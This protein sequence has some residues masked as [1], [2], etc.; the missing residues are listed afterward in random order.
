MMNP[1]NSISPRPSFG[2]KRQVTLVSITRDRG[3]S[4]AFSGQL[5]LRGREHRRFRVARGG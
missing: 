4:P 2:A 1:M 3:D 5:D